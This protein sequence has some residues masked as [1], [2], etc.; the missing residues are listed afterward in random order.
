MSNMRS[1]GVSSRLY[2]CDR[3]GKQFLLSHGTVLVT[4]TI[5]LPRKL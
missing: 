4:M 2:T 1:K 5:E 3:K